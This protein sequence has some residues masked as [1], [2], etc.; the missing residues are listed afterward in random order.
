MDTLINQVE[1]SATHSYF[2]SKLLKTLTQYYGKTP[3]FGKY[4]PGIKDILE[5]PYP[6]AWELNRDLLFYCAKALNLRCEIKIASSF[7]TQAEKESRIIDLVKQV[8]GTTY[9][10]GNGAKDYQVPEHFGKEGIELVYSEF[11]VKPY[12]QLYGAFIGGLSIVDSL[13]NK[14]NP[15]A[16]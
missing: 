8:G 7:T 1:V 6:Y 2:V 11:K 4:F 3:C 15:L 12:E 13:F 5:R 16:L 14:E 10:S 9:I